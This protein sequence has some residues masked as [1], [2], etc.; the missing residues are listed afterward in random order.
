MNGLGAVIKEGEKMCELVPS[1]NE[2]SLELYV[3]PID[4]PLIAKGQTVQLVF[5]GWPAFVFSGW[6]GMSYGTFQAQIIAFDRVI[7]PNGKFRVLAKQSGQKWPDQIQNGCGSKGFAL[8]NNVPLI[9][10]LWRKINGFPPDFYST[11]TNTK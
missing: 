3:D 10:E 11:K 1:T 5:D 6:P 8:L 9:Y 7:S 4:L 2:Q